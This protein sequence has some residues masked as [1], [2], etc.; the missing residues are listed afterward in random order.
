[1]IEMLVAVAITMLVL[2]VMVPLTVVWLL[3]RQVR[4]SRSFR[5]LR[6]AR[7]RVRTAPVRAVAGGAAPLLRPWNR[8]AVDATHARERFVRTV[9]QVPPGPLRSRLTDVAREVD[10]AVA[11]AQ[12]LAREGS[13]T[14]RAYREVSAALTQQR[15][16]SRSLTAAPAD[17]AHD[18]LAS[19][20]AQRASAQRLEH[21]SQ[22]SLC[23]LQLIV[24]RLHE[25]TAHTL[26]LS[27]GTHVTPDRLAVSSLAD[28]VAALRE[29]TAEVEQ[30]D[31]RVAL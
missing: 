7:A 19:T 21:A 25:L 5:R 16:R 4:R 6:A 26:E 22:Q 18:L 9:E 11:D 12:W 13:A 2:A 3:V 17:L 8:L 29:A 20:R 27:M 24:A 10:A 31:V 14:D 15:R 28:H 30:I 1:M 23:Q